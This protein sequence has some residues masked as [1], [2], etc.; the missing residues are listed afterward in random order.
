ML[1][2]HVAQ[3]S[4]SAASPSGAV[5]SH[6]EGNSLELVEF[7]TLLQVTLLHTAS[8]FRPTCLFSMTVD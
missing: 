5:G 6:G 3:A 4:P 2:G 7:N 8:H 1:C